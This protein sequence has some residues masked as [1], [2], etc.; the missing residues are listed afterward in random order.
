MNTY[1]KIKLLYFML[2][3]KF[4]V[5]FFYTPYNNIIEYIEN[6]KKIKYVLP[7][8]KKNG[9]VKTLRMYNFISEIIYNSE[10][11]KNY[12]TKTLQ[13]IMH[14]YLN[15]NDNG[16]SN[17][18]NLKNISYDGISE[19]RLRIVNNEYIFNEPYYT[20]SYCSNEEKFM[21][22]NLKMNILENLDGVLKIKD[23][24]YVVKK[25]II[26]SMDKS[27]LNAYSDDSI[28]EIYKIIRKYILISLLS[29]I[30]DEIDEEKKMLYGDICSIYHKFCN[31]YD[32]FFLYYII[33]YD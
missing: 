2:L 10:D 18:H 28:N 27:K 7:F 29:N 1:Q 13:E 12:F 14:K 4:F 3:H 21:I 20:I 17:F 31:Y 9:N 32:K 19:F 22:S 33:L 6:Y 16:R 30:Y 15:D 25:S 23:Y 5:L 26:K 8:G 24:T 11:F